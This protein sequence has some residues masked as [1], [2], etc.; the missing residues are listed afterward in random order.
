GIAARRGTPHRVGRFSHL[1]RR[2]EQLRTILLAGE[3]LEPPRGLLG[4]VR[5]GTLLRAAARG[6][7]GAALLQPPL[8]LGF[9]FLPSR[10]LLQLPSS[11]APPAAAAG[12]SPSAWGP[13]G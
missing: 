1:P 10:K 4:L 7:G 9:L 3:P 5:Q 2:V 11:P 8:A 12:R 13:A 6:R